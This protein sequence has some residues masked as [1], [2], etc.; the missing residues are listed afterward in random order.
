MKATYIPGTWLVIP[1]YHSP[2]R[3]TIRKQ[4]PKQKK[5]KK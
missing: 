5:E 1:A 2:T 3:R 4:K